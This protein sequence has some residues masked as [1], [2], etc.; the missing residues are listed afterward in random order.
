MT[1]A[2][3]AAETRVLRC[4]PLTFTVGHIA[5]CGLLSL[6][7]TRRM[8]VQYFSGASLSGKTTIIRMLCGLLTPTGGEV[9]VL[10]LDIPARAEQ[11][12]TGVP[13]QVL[14]END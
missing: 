6:L 2:G 13:A 10:G 11:L 3:A 5:I 9:S 4:D 14:L 7:L 1:S 12:P 8:Q